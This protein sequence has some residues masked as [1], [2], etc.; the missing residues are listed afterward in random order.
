[1]LWGSFDL[2]YFVVPTP[3]GWA[4]RLLKFINLPIV[5]RFVRQWVRDWMH[6]R[7][8]LSDMEDLCPH[9]GKIAWLDCHSIPYPT[10]GRDECE[11][12]ILGESN[13]HWQTHRDEQMRKS[14]N[15][16][17]ATGDE[18]NR[19]HAK[20]SSMAVRGDVAPRTEK[21]FPSCASQEAEAGDDDIPF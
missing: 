20:P 18:R 17:T 2:G 14:E 12:A 16:K 7:F 11:D 3:T 21:A 5:P 13:R 1:M 6:S 4:L 9:C 10:C 8:L 19:S 15:A